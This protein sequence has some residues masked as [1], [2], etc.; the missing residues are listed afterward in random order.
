M[1]KNNNI[2]SLADAAAA[3]GVPKKL[4]REQIAELGIVNWMHAAPTQARN[5]Q[6]GEMGDG[7]FVTIADDNGEEFQSFI[8]NIALGNILAR[9]DLPF[10]AGIKKSGRTWV[11]YDES[12]QTF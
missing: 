5:P 8:G 3:A 7:F 1:T 2:R 9:V 4:S 10:R 11:F 12:G 6:T